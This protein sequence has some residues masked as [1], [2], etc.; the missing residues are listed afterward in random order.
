MIP[1]FDTNKWNKEKIIDYVIGNQ[2]LDDQQLEFLNYFDKLQQ[3]NQELIHLVANKVIADY[4]YDSVLKEE[5]NNERLKVIALEDSKN[6]IENIL[7]KFEKWLEK[8][9]DQKIYLNF[10]TY[11]HEFCAIAMVELQELK[12]GKK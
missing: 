4:N 5:L 11:F 12:E 1:N 6:D 3:E 10:E 7:I 8:G 9:I 2:P